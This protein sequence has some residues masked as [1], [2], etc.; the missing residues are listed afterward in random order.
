MLP[1]KSICW[2]RLD[3]PRYNECTMF[4]LLLPQMILTG[5]PN[6]NVYVVPFS[7]WISCIDILPKIVYSRKKNSQSFPDPNPVLFLLVMT[8]SYRP[9]KS[10]YSSFIVQIS[11][12]IVQSSAASLPCLGAAENPKQS[13]WCRMC[14]DHLWSLWIAYWVSRGWERQGVTIRDAMSL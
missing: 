14:W 5:P 9:V 8:G 3:I 2:L 12:S 4:S 7:Y 13:H 1:T 6:Y 11:L 10:V